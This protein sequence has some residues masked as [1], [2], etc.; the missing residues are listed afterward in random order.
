MWLR[1][2]NNDVHTAFMWLRTANADHRLSAECKKSQCVPGIRL[3]P[4]RLLTSF[5]T[6]V[7][8]TPQLKLYNNPP[9]SSLTPTSERTRY[10]FV[11]SRTTPISLDLTSVLNRGASVSTSHLYR[12]ADSG[13]TARS[14]TSCAPLRDF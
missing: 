4:A 1:R 3:P 12:P 13:R 7:L 8:Q 11:H 2:A 14:V 5:N 9:C 10:V 6:H